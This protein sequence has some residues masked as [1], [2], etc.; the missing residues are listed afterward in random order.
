MKKKEKKRFPLW[1][2]IYVIWK[3]FNTVA[4]ELDSSE[5]QNNGY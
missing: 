1:N 2:F 3:C 5:S 4:E